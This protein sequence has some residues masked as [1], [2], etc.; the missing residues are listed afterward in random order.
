MFSLYR[1]P[2]PVSSRQVP[3]SRSFDFH[4]EAYFTCG[5]KIVSTEKS[6]ETVTHVHVREH[7][8]LRLTRCVQS[9]HYTSVLGRVFVAVNRANYTSQEFSA[10]LDPSTSLCRSNCDF[11][12]QE[13]LSQP[14][15]LSSRDVLIST[16]NHTSPVDG[17]V[18]HRK[19]NWDGDSCPCSCC[20]Q[21]Q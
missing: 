6:T 17:N 11:F 16:Q 4:S 20:S 5:W 12:V 3:I 14:L 18:L 9:V 7:S 19:I 21:P 1:N 10:L 8:R 2:S 15:R 13:P